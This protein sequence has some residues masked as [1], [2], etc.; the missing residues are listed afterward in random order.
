[1]MNPYEELLDQED[2]DRKEAPGLLTRLCRHHY[3]DNPSERHKVLMLAGEIMHDDP[4]LGPS[5][6]VQ[7]ALKAVRGQAG[8]M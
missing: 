7:R 3:P 8:E 4:D 5:E 2:L 1:M 6:A